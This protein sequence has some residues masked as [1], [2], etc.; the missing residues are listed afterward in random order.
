[1]RMRGARDSRPVDGEAWEAVTF[2]KKSNQKTFA[3]LDR[4]RFTALG[5]VKKSVLA[6]FCSQK[7]VLPFLC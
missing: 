2:L 3:T 7:E 6:S 5:L 4:V 1:M